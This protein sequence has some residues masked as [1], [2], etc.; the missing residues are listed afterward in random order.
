MLTADAWFA[1]IV[2]MYQQNQCNY[3]YKAKQISVVV[4]YNLSN[5]Y[6]FILTL[7]HAFMRTFK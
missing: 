7:L 3:Y 4:N 2:P 1:E 5:Y 6:I